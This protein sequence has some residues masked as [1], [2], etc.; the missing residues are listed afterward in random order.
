VLVYRTL[1]LTRLRRNELRTL[2]VGDLELTPCGELLR[3]KAANEKSGVG[4]TIPL[5]ADLADELRS[6]IAERRLTPA[7]RVFTVP[8]GL[9]LILNR[10]L[11]AAGI[12]K[13]D[14]RGR[15]DDVRHFP[16][17]HRHGTQDG[18][19]RHATLGHQADDGHLHRPG[20]ARR[21]ARDGESAG[22]HRGREKE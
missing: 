11:K 21:A 20:A 17:H 2:T 19:S 1:V 14:A 9:R 12:P 22:V 6:W 15:T 3:L 4:S 7:D 16:V 10:D 5:R 13:R 18:T 8:A